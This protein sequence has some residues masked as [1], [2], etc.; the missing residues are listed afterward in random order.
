MPGQAHSPAKP[1]S[2]LLRLAVACLCICA[3]GGCATV[4]GHMT[5]PAPFFIPSGEN[6]LPL[7]VGVLVA[8]WH[9]GIV[10]PQEELGPLKPLLES[11]RHAGYLSFGWGNQRFYMAAHPGSGDALA[12]LFRSPSALFVQAVPSPRDLL[13]SDVHIHW[14]C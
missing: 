2:G 6:H 12:A 4:P 7:E 3:M 9:S 13:G 10:L 5:T 8:G 11:C 14:V 1:P